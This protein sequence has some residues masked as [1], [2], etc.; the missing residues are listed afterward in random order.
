M[1]WYWYYNK[2]KPHNKAKYLR[3]HIQYTKDRIGYFLQYRG[4]SEGTFWQ[5]LKAVDLAIEGMKND[6]DNY[7][8]MIIDL[9]NIPE[10]IKQLQ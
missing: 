7:E 4:S 8:Q 2:C 5:D 10:L 1:N 3:K 9:N 6:I